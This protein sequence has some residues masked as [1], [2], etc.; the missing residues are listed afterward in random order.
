MNERS[1]VMVVEDDIDI[2]EAIVSAL[3][4][5]GYSAIAA[6]NGQEALD[7]LRQGAKLPNLILLD[8]TM[9]V[10]DGREFQ[11]AQKSDPAL[12]DIPLVLLSAQSDIR[13]TAKEMGAAAWLLKPVQ[14]AELLE[15]LEA[16]A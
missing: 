14:L 9:P 3:Q 11:A 8:L 6:K 5:Y 15:V 4:A 12:A 16:Y 1:I 10:M 7:K 2:S 13:S